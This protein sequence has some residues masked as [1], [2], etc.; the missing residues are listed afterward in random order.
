MWLDALDD[1]RPLIMGWLL[2]LALLLTFTGLVL[3]S[4]EADS[5]VTPIA[6]EQQG[7]KDA[8][9]V[10]SIGLKAP[11]I[12]IEVDPKGVLSPPDNT[13]LVGWWKRSAQPG[14]L[15]GQTV[16][17]GHT[18]HAGG[19]VMNKLG[20]VKPGQVVQ[21][22]DE[23]KLVDY[24]V[25]KVFV[26]TK[27]ELAAHAKELFAQDRMAGRLVLITCTDWVKGDYLSNIIVFAQPVRDAAAA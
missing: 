1:R 20:K 7:G 12:P 19:G 21:V 24:R 23:G 3:P 5:P 25:T 11:I 22:R 4:E 13:K 16:I 17:T 8:L 10:P 14:A 2:I 18:V 27:A 15:K 6:A 9:L 26:Y